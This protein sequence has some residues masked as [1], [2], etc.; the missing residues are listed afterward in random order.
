MKTPSECS[1]EGVFLWGDHQQ[2]AF[3]GLASLCV[4]VGRRRNHD[5]AVVQREPG[6]HARETFR[7]GL[8]GEGLQGQGHT[9]GDGSD[10]THTRGTGDGL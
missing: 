8:G 2:Q 6:R 1:S 9:L 5:L 3:D 7:S 4:A 10:L